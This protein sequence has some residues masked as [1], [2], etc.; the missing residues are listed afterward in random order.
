MAYGKIVGAIGI[1]GALWAQ[2]STPPALSSP[3]D[4]QPATNRGDMFTSLT[5]FSLGAWRDCMMLLKLD[6]VLLLLGGG[7]AALLALRKRVAPAGMVIGLMMAVCFATITRGYSLMGQY[8]SLADAAKAINKTAAPGALVV[9]EGEPHLNSSLFFYLHH[10]VHWINARPDNEFALRS[11]HRGSEL[12]PSEERLAAWWRSSQQVFL[13]LEASHLANWE[14]K[15]A[16]TSSQTQ[17]LGRSGT[18]IVI[19]NH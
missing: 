14:K 1:S 10:R 19:V 16:L 13:I 12:Y 9:C 8:F 17:P 7:T 15:L 4:A 18:R 5:G 11:L 2:F 6:G 3:I